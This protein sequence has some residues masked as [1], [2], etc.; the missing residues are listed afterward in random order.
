MLL[1]II[2]FGANVFVL[3]V[4]VL[5]AFAAGLSATDF[6]K[7]KDREEKHQEIE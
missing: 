5:L 2:G 3:I 1:T 4:I 6:L 7:T